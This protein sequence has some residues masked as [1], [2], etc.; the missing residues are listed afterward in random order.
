MSIEQKDLQAMLMQKSD[1]DNKIR[2]VQSNRYAFESETISTLMKMNKPY[3]FT[4]NWAALKREAL[5]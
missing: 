5:R 1:L 4:I 3:F 2:E